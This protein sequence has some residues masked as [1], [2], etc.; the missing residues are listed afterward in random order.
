MQADY[1]IIGAGT[2]GSIVA[3]KLAKNKPEST[4]ILLEAGNEILTDDLMY[5]DPKLWKL[6]TQN[7]KNEWQYQ[8]VLQPA[9]NNRIISM[10]RAKAMGGCSIHNAMIYVRGGKT[11]FDDWARL[12]IKGWN[13]SDVLPYFDEIENIFNIT[14]SI[15]DVFIRDLIQSCENNNISYN[16]NYNINTDLQC[17][18][19]FQFL[20]DKNGKRQTPYHLLIG[21][22]PNLTN[23]IRMPNMLAKK[24]ILSGKDVVGV[25]CENHHHETFFIKTNKEIILS[26]GAIGSPQILMLSGIG[27]KKSLADL[28]INTLINLPGVGKNFQDD[29]YMITS[30]KTKKP[31]PEQPY[32]MMGAVIFTRGLLNHS[33]MT[34][35]IECSLSTGDMLGRSFLPEQLPSFQIFPNIQLLKNRGEVTLKNT[36]PHE[37]PLINPNYLSNN[38][39]LH[40]CVDTIKMVRKIVRNSALSNWYSHELSP[41][42]NIRTDKQI[43]IYV[44]STAETAYHY[45]GTCAMGVNEM[46]VVNPETLLVR[47]TNNLRIIDASII[48]QTVSGNTAAATMMIAAKGADIVLGTVNEI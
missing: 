41:G 35:D 7:I 43:E 39:D 1:I 44:R 46:A 21:N 2:A 37:H 4:I 15:E 5:W 29:L 8:S 23:I 42:E 13:Y 14:T 28:N 30:F 16:S 9:L 3:H 33:K 38:D 34:T 22:Q 27:D 18:S 12:G 45:A 25:E 17:I 11:G 36:N 47:E 6:S 19:P 32:G 40:R 10:S 24:I 26:A 48:P 20:I 31:L